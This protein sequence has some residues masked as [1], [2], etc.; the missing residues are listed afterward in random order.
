MPIYSFKCKACGYTHDSIMKFSE[1]E[2]FIRTKRCDCGGEL[3]TAMTRPA[4]TPGL[5]GDQTGTYGVNGYYSKALGAYVDNKA[6]ERKIMEKRGFIA[7]SD[8]PANFWADETERR[9]NKLMEQEREVQTIEQHLANG[10]E[11][12]EAIANT[13]TAERC[14]SGELDAIYDNVVDHSIEEN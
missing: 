4:K 1:R 2:N 3:K 5:W 10:Y 12:G 11:M 13:F 8:L 14:L 9:K 6:A 7:E